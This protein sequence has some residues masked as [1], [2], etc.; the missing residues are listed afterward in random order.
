MKRHR[1]CD[2]HWT[3]LRSPLPCDY[4]KAETTDTKELQ[5]SLMPPH[6]AFF[7]NCLE[8]ANVSLQTRH[9]QPP[10]SF[11]SRRGRSAMYLQQTV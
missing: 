8:T 5:T 2:L 1:I 7:A 3:Q 9:L 11:F 4:R 10:F 6:N